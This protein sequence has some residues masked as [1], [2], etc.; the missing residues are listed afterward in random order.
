MANDCI[1][2]NFSDHQNNWYT[3]VAW[4]CSCKHKWYPVLQEGTPEDQLECPSCHAQ[5]SVMINST[6]ILEHAEQLNEA[7]FYL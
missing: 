6:E 1:V 4:C 7:G 5:N 2:I 3:G